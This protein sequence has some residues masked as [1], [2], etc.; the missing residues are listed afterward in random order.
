M[1]KSWD[2]GIKGCI[3]G[4]AVDGW[5]IQTVM[6]PWF[7]FYGIWMD[8]KMSLFTLFVA[9]I[10]T[11]ASFFFSMLESYTAIRQQALEVSLQ[12]TS[13]C[14][15][16]LMK[17][18]GCTYLRSLYR[19]FRKTESCCPK[20]SSTGKHNF[21]LAK[22]LSSHARSGA[23]WLSSSIFKCLLFNIAEPTRLFLKLPWVKQMENKSLACLGPTCD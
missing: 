10:E 6:Q 14:S 20:L 12:Q 22:L 16:F 15:I 21:K 18:S 3:V 11:L 17:Y 1:Q 5:T 9:S 23:Q 2:A 13:I 4:W 19:C 8:F 7:L